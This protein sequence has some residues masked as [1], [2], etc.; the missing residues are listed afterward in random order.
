[1]RKIRYIGIIVIFNSLLI[2]CGSN[3]KTYDN[4]SQNAKKSNSVTGFFHSVVNKN[5]RVVK[6]IGGSSVA[7]KKIFN[8]D[9]S[10]SCSLKSWE[11]IGVFRNE[12]LR[13]TQGEFVF[14]IKNY[15]PEKRSWVI[16]ELLIL[17]EKGNVQTTS[18]PFRDL[19]GEIIQINPPIEQGQTKTLVRGWKYRSGWHNVT[20]KTCQWA[21]SGADYFEKYPEL[22]NYPIP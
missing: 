3:F 17:D 9:E 19:Q 11:L 15:A 12:Q 6:K 4:S 22:K 16:F 21:N 18:N 13:T 5:D 10:L 1:M 7:G 14:E 2:A 20:L 8:P